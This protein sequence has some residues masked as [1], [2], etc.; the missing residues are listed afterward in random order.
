MRP[1]KKSSIVRKL[2]L[3]SPVNDYLTRFNDFQYTWLT[4]F[5]RGN[6][7]NTLLGA[8]DCHRRKFIS[9]RHDGFR[10]SDFSVR[11]R[12][13]DIHFSNEGELVD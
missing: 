1:A 2:W 6:F 9:D 7:Y 11:G 3:L 10:T 4:D 13:K 12:L 8:Y 5:A